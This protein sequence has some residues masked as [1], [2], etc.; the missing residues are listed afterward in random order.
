MSILYRKSITGCES[1][2]IR[3]MIQDMMNFIKSQYEL[4]DDAEYEFRLILNEL[5]ANGTVHGNKRL[6]NKSITAQIE[7]IDQNTVSITIQDE[8]CGFDYSSFFSNAYPC[9]VDLYSEGGRGLKLIKA[10]C[11]SI[12]FNEVGNQIKIC[13]SVRKKSLL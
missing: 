5:I 3:S 4:T 2:C 8:G 10:I 6:C 7:T 11:D 13:K 1:S 9:D 12:R